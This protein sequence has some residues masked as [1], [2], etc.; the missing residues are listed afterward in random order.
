MIGRLIERLFVQVQADLSQL[1]GQLNQGVAQTQAATAKM[2]Q[3]W[4]SVNTQVQSL[5]SQLQKGIITQSQYL[6]QMNRLASSATALAGSYRQAQ[7]QVFGFAVAA[8]QAAAAMPALVNPAP[9][10]RFT[11]SLGQSRMQMMNLGY[12]LND[13]GMTL[14]TGMNPMTVL[15]QQGSQ[16]MQIY[17]GQGGVRAALGDIGNIIGALGKRLWPLAILAGGFGILQREINKTSG[18]AVSFG[19]TVSAVFQVLGRYIYPFIEGPL[20]DL[21]S[22]FNAV[23]DF[24]AEWFPKVMNGVIA[25]GIAM[26][27]IIGATWDLLPRLWD[28]AWTAIKNTAIDAI[29]A[30]ANFVTQDLVNN[31]LAGVNRIIQAFSFAYEGVKIIWSK[32]PDILKDAIGGAVNWVVDGAEKMV[33]VAIGGINKLIAGLQSLMDFVGA[34]AALEFF[35]FSGQLKPLDPA[36]LSTWRMETGS[37][38]SDTAAELGALAG[39]V[40]NQNMMG[41]MASIDPLDLSGSKGA[42]HNAFS[43]LGRRIGEI[44]GQAFQGTDYMGQFF[45]DVKAQAI[46]NA[47]A[48][49]AAG[50]EDI[51]TAAGRAAEEVKTLMDM[52]DEKLTGAAESL[53]E[54]FGSAFER[55]AETGR[56]TFGDFVQ[57]L[58]RLIIKSTSEILQQE[59]ANMFKSLALSKGGL[60]GLFSNLFTNLFGGF[61]AMGARARG[62]TEMPWRNF[63][64][65]EEGA[66]LI[67]QDG[68]SGARRVTTAG[69]T[70]HLLNGSGGAAPVV[71]MYIQ[72]PDVQ[73]FQKSQ[74]QL[75]SRM[76][77]FISSGRRNQ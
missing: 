28:D 73:S 71:N 15:I 62:G 6:S 22:G 31:V 32:L 48:R 24:I 76:G 17:A 72:T 63:I 30:I 57:D 77:R 11:R 12:Q 52:L 7:Q 2:A 38:M 10:Q 75:A 35:G 49:V 59:L 65:G 44:V 46:V 19:D 43:E 1:S 45:E 4:S 61:N 50:M 29:E 58:N 18:V 56:F 47:Q 69:R 55:L 14:S 20:N 8:R 25:A 68:P 21:M 26:V 13:I 53:A 54:V 37:A 39:R 67:S 3:S 34:D 9:V 64:A 60:G 74:S 33:N 70:R 40:F 41:E 16:I 51:G 23:I 27:K 42:S 66:E 5:H 36:D